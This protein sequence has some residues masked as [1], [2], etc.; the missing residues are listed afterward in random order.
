MSKGNSVGRGA[1]RMFIYVFCI[2][3]ALLSLFPFIIMFVNATRSTYEIQQRG[4][5]LIP[6]G[7]LVNNFKILTGK[8][9]DSLRGLLL[10][11]HG[12]CTRRLFMEN[13]AG[14]FHPHSLHHDDSGSGNQHRFL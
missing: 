14:I 5:S 11:A 3:L 10:N 9:F 1:F 13:E 2:L 6:S 8:T 12:L 7:Y 4:V